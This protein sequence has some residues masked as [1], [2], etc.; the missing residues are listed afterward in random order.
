[1]KHDKINAHVIFTGTDP[2]SSSGGIGVVMLGYFEAMR[3]AGLPSKCIP[4]YHPQKIGGKWL[5]WLTSIP[6]LLQTIRKTRLKGFLPV[7]YSHAGAGFSL[8][9]ESCILRICK[10]AGAKTVLHIHAP[11]VDSYLKDRFKSLLFKASLIPADIVIV[12]TPW[13]QS[14]LKT[15]GVKR[16]VQ[17]IPNPLPP[18]LENI[19]RQKKDHSDGHQ[20]SHSG[21]ISV[22]IIA[23]LVSG[24]GVDVVIKAMRHLP[25][26]VKL[27]VA[28]DGAERS[29]LEKLAQKP[30][31]R[32]RVRFVGWVSGNEKSRLL[33][34]ADV[35]CLP[36]TN[37]AF[38]ISFVE[39]M[40]Y[41]LPVIGVKWGGIPDMVADGRVG[42]LVD[43]PDPGKVAETI[44][45]I[46][47]DER[48]RQQMSMEAKK[49]V[50]EISKAEVVGGKLK[51]LFE[52]LASH[53]S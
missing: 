28:G 32:Q 50:L 48:L 44:K 15:A 36:S 21:P 16:R 49:W 43:A 23:R 6:K 51:E 8:F 27:I 38:S 47:D 2:E 41:G 1:V 10:L 31:L 9:R 39:A 34:N 3:S 22:L 37:D 33:E 53:S 13:W 42:V 14:R 26:T 5:L 18:V 30:G 35:F 52:Q 25:P 46:A 11:Q 4:T 20:T 17:V 7:V 19:A 29:N 24:K 45:R 12:L 40:S